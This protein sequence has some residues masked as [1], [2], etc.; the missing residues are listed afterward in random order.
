MPPGPAQAEYRQVAAGLQSHRTRRPPGRITLEATIRRGL[1][2]ARSQHG[3]SGFAALQFAAD[4][5]AVGLLE[6]QVLVDA[7]SL[8]IAKT[9]DLFD[10]SI[11]FLVGGQAR[12][13][14]RAVGPGPERASQPRAVRST[15]VEARGC[16]S[17]VSAAA[18]GFTGY[19]ASS[20]C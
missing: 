5:L 1:R 11:P 10:R 2:P 13:P 4:P 12:Q 20:I 9:M 18:A 16:T 8:K 3:D 17:A 19:S 7:S 6:A 15:T 14:R